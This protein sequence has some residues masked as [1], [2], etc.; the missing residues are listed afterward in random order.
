MLLARRLLLTF[1]LLGGLVATASTSADHATETVD[2]SS[3]NAESISEPGVSKD[4]FSSIISGNAVFTAR[5][6]KAMTDFG[7]SARLQEDC[8]LSVNFEDIFRH[9][10]LVYEEHSMNFSWKPC[11]FL[12]IGAS[13]VVCRSKKDYVEDPN[14]TEWKTSNQTGVNLIFL[15]E[16]CDWKF[17][18]RNRVEYREYCGYGTDQWK[19]RN[20]LRITAPTLSI[21]LLD[22][23]PYVSAEAYWSD[24]DAFSGHEKWNTLI[25][26]AGF[27]T[28]LTDAF[29]FHFYFKTT[30]S[31]RPTERGGGWRCTQHEPY[32]AISAAF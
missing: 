11:V 20:L 10:G 17:Y 16:L 32:F 3:S 15:G 4:A 19:Y 5:K 2:D 18:D 22:L 9:R 12:R 6:H 31:R 21:P 27:R 28:K 23:A 1:L 25:N 14:V 8:R 13:D 24:N 26:K 7:F 30:H 29:R